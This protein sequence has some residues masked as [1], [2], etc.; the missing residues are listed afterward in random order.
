MRRR[1]A[2]VGCVLLCVLPATVKAVQTLDEFEDVKAWSAQASPGASLEIAQDAGKT[3][4]AMRLDFDFRGGGGFVIARK[5][6]ALTLPANFAFTLRDPRRRAAELARVQADRADQR[7]R[8]VARAAR[9]RVPEGL[10]ARRH[11]EVAPRVRLG[12]EADVVAEEGRVPRDRDHDRRGRQRLGLDRRLEARGA[13]D[14]EPRRPASGRDRLDLRARARAAARPR[15]GSA[16]ELAERRASPPS[17]GCSSISRN[18]A[19]TA[20]SSSTGIPSTTRPSYR[21][22]V[23]DDAE[24]WTLAYTSIAGQGGRSY[25]YLPDGESRYLRLE[26]LQSSQGKG[27]EIRSLA[28]K[29]IAFSA[30]PNQFFEAIAASAVSRHVPQI[31]HRPAVVLD[32]RRRRRRRQRSADERGGHPRGRQGRVHDRALPLR[33]RRARHLERRAARAGARRARA[34][35]SRR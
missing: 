27:Y 30:S 6:F 5:A 15:P 4:N 7:Q 33:R 34:L 22:Q 35:R 10:A 3:G 12:P 8:L 14:H 1:I 32:R 16:D 19:S 26:L 18:A 2:G 24:N 29:P 31:L 17:S 23:S 13:R 9:L 28:V 21:V 20:A 11:Q 25:V